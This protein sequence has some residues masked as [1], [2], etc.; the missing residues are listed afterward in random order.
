MR[1]A[2]NSRCNALNITGVSMPNNRIFILIALKPGDRNFTIAMTD[3]PI[4]WRLIQNN[5]AEPA[6]YTQILYVDP[7]TYSST[8][9]AKARRDELT[10]L[11]RESLLA[12]IKESNPE[13]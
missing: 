5:D 9:E 10:A 1:V 6:F 12:L 4:A 8:D 13:L 2:M 11:P 7:K 3:S